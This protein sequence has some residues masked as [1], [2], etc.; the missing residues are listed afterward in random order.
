MLKFLIEKEFKQ[1]FRNA[2]LP[3]L[4]FI[5]PVFMMILL[6]WAANMEVKNVY[7]NI[8]DNDHSPISERLVHK[9]AASGYFKLNGISASYDEAMKSVEEGTADVIMEITPDFERNL[10]RGE[11]GRILL[12]ANTVNGTKGSLGSSYLSTIINEYGMELRAEQTIPSYRAMSSQQPT[13]S[14]QLSTVNLYN[15]NLNYKLF[16]VPALMV[17]LLTLL[18]GFLPALNIVGEKEKGTI[19]Q[20]NVTPVGKFTFI[21]AKLLPYWVVGFVVLTICF[22]LAWLFYGIFPVGHLIVIY[23]YAAIFIL[24]VSGLGLV[25]SNSSATMQQAMFVMFFCLIILMLMSGLFTPIASMPQWAQVITIFN[26]L[27]YMIEVLRTVYLKGGGFSDLT[28]QLWAL[29]GFAVLLNT[30]AVISYR[31]NN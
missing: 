27:K 7:L 15:P 25:I 12:S 30:W 18:C 3:K 16:I 14:C 22:G 11:T 8:V 2:F 29:I 13:V 21:L 9:I 23:T 5:F 28:V 17:M 19:E 4:I 31:K 1:L 26:P 10:M 6:P 24:A 20:I